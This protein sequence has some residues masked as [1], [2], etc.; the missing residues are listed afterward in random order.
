MHSKATQ[1]EKEARREDPT[2]LNIIAIRKCICVKKNIYIDAIKGIWMF[3]Y[4][5]LNDL[6]SAV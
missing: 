4:T 5:F 3:L 2:L 6:R 1:Q